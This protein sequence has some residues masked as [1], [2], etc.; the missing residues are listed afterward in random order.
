[1]KMLLQNSTGNLKV[2]GADING[3]VFRK[4]VL[5]GYKFIGFVWGLNVGV[6]GTDVMTKDKQEIVD[7]QNAIVHDDQTL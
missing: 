3:E 5:E 6:S 4:L 7:K 1:M 2:S